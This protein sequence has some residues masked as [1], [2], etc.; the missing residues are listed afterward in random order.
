MMYDMKEELLKGMMDMTSKLISDVVMKCGEKYGFSG[1]SELREMGILRLNVLNKVS[2]VKGNNKL[3]SAFPLPFS[4]EFDKSKCH[5]VALNGGLM[6]QCEV[7]CSGGSCYCKAHGKQSEKSGVGIPEHGTMMQR[8]AVDALEYV[9]PS[10]KTP[11]AYRKLMSKLSLSEEDVRMEAKRMNVKLDERHFEE[12]VETK[13]GRPKV[14][15]VLEVKQSK[16]RPKKMSKVVEL[17]SSVDDIFATT[18]SKVVEEVV[19]ESESESE[20][21]LDLDS[22]SKENA[23]M[24]AADKESKVSN[25]VFKKEDNAAKLKAEKAE[26]EA[27]L[28]AEKAEKEAKLKAEKAEKEA[29]LKAEKA[30]KE[31]K[32]KAE[33]AEKEAKLKAEKAEKAEKEAK[34]KA[35][36]ESKSKSKS[37]VDV[38]VKVPPTVEKVIT[39][40]NDLEEEVVIEKVSKFLHKGVEYLKSSSGVVYNMDQDEVG[41]WNNVTNDIDLMSEDSEEEEDEEC[42]AEEYEE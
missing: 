32:L 6:T 30:E 25:K 28:K 22:C 29:K 38:G 27:K 33:K 14:E 40:A 9:S 3:K 12:V 18:L 17:S 15:K 34:L 31:A 1:E 2:V 19:S 20:T 8:M 41:K 4:G 7:V 24:G 23:S 39:E 10:G 5:G 26:K 16:G 37:K 35:E 36:K 11:M 42:E 13:K 21:E